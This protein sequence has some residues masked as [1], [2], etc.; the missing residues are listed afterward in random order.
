MIGFAVLLL[1]LVFFAK[2]LQL[3]WR[4]GLLLTLCYAAYM[5]LTLL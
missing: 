2:G 3:S 1:P 5:A 4:Q